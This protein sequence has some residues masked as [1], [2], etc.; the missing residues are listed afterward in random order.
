MEKVFPYC[1]SYVCRGWDLHGRHPSSGVVGLSACKRRLGIHLYRRQ[2]QLGSIKAFVGA[3]LGAFTG[4]LRFAFF[5]IGFSLKVIS[6]QAEFQSAYRE[7]V[8][9]A[10]QDAATALRTPR[11]NR[12]CN[13]YSAELPGCCF[14]PQVRWGSYLYFS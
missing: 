1:V 8:A 11:Y 5:L 10:L 2:Q 7:M 12:R 14:L 9:K 4:L 6:H 13:P 3:R